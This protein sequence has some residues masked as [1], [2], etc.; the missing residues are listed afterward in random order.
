VRL[1]QAAPVSELFLYYSH[2][3]KQYVLLA[4]LVLLCRI[5][6]FDVLTLCRNA[7]PIF[8]A[9]GW[10]S[11]AAALK[12]EAF[13]SAETLEQAQLTALCGVDSATSL[14]WSL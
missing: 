7:L 4:K 2:R 3:C 8:R 12:Q 10:C 9:S 14:N 13:R 6:C 11:D 1:V 5:V